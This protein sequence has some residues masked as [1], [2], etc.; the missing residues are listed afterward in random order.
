[1]LAKIAEMPELDRVMAE[2]I[3]AIITASAPILAPKT[4]YGMSAYA[5]DGKVACFFQSA[6]KFSTR[7]ATLGFN[8]TAN[9]DDGAMWPTAFAFKELTPDTSTQ[10]GPPPFKLIGPEAR[11]LAMRGQGATAV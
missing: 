6:A 9:L 10:H 4:W 7:Y 8:D 2:R 11:Q 5:R 1:M 3:H